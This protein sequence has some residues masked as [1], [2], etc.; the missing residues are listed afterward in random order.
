M[1]REASHQKGK[2]FQRGVKLW[3]RDRPLL[4]YGARELGDAYDITRTSAELGGE[5]FDFS[6]ALVKNGDAELVLYA[7]CKYRHPA[8]DDTSPLLRE[9]V[10]RVCGALEGCTKDERDAAR[11]LFITNV[12]PDELRRFVGKRVEY[13]RDILEIDDCNQPFHIVA[14]R[15][16][17]LVIPRDL[18]AVRSSWA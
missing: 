3:L 6:L 16:N 8:A 12:P 17:A 7:E 9:F 5:S 2:D 11:F 10:V 4:G 13:C 14:E 1:S 18:I 15:A